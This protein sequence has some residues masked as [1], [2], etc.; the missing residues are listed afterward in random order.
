[1]ALP[2]KGDPRRPLHLA[3]RSMRLLGA[4]LILFATCAG[5]TFGLVAV[6]VAARGM[7]VWGM[8]FG[9]LFYLLP[10]LVFIILAMYVKQRQAWAVA[11]SI[12]VTSVGAMVVLLGLVAVVFTGVSDPGRSPA[13]WIAIGALVLILAALGQLIYLLSRSFEAIRCA[14]P[15][16][17]GFEPVMAQPLAAP[18]QQQVQRTWA[19]E[20][21]PPATPNRDVRDGHEPPAS[22]PTVA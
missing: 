1:M 12:C 17:R 21:P 7:P 11:A 4:I 19:P 6:R 14:P 2:P 20:V 8:A 18:V 16:E 3:V 5:V 15:D 22:P 10:G 9:I 13:I